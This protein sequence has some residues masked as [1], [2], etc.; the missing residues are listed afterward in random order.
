MFERWDTSVDLA[1]GAD[2][3]AI[4]NAYKDSIAKL[5]KTYGF[6]LVDTAILTPDNPNK[7]DIRKQ[8][9]FEHTHNDF[10]VGF[11]V[12]GSGLFYFHVDDKVYLLLCGKGDL[13]SV[14]AMINHWFDM[15]ENPD[16][17]LIRFFPTEDGW[18]ANKSGS[19]IASRLSSM[20]VFAA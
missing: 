9:Y 5:N 13:I 16:F 15:G 7:A 1:Y 2:Q 11:F 19:D 12:E 18:V 17:K 10:E 4:L 14:P 3:E 6:E 8:F 20:D